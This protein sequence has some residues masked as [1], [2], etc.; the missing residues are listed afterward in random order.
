M[1]SHSFRAT[2]GF[3]FQRIFVCQAC[4]RQAI[5]QQKL[6]AIKPSSLFQRCLLQTSTTPKD[7]VPFRKQLKDEAKR[8]WP[9]GNSEVSKKSSKGC[10]PRLEKWELTVGIEIHAELNTARK[11]FSSAAT[12]S[13]DAPNTHVAL[14]D[15]AFPGAQPHFQ[16]ETLIPALRAAIAL[17]CEIQPKSSFDRKHYFYQDQ[18][19]GYQI[20]QYYG[21]TL[22]ILA[23]PNMLINDLRAI[24]E[25]WTHHSLRS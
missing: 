18:P 16:R 20:T 3:S 7:I 1:L 23:A 15:V 12:S 25:R 22:A 19:A 17:H 5:I 4:I 14:F 21:T 13:S 9:K 11:L 8:K 10:D 24:C 2:P 6:T